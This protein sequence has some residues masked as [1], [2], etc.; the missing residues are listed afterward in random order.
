MINLEEKQE[1]VL[2]VGVETFENSEN[3][4][5]SM[6]ELAEL[7][8]TAGGIVIDAFTQKRD[9]YDTK[10]L[11]GTGKLEQMRWA[12]E[13]G[14]IDTVIFNDRLTPR[15]N[16]NLEEALG[17]KVIDRMQLILD[18]FALRARSH[19][20]MLQVEQAQLSYLLPRLVGQGIMLSRQG[21]GI[22]SK[23][24]GESKLE[25]D[26]RYIRT[27]I[28]NIDKQLQ[29][30]E[31][32]RETIRKKRKESSIF[33]IGLIGYTN[34]GKSSIMNALTEKTQYEKDEL[35]ATLDATTKLVKIK[36]DFTVSLTDTVGF[37]QDLPTELIKAFKSTLEESTHV[38]LLIHVIDASNPHHEVHEKTVQ[39]L[40]EEMD[41]Q[42]IPVL[43][44]YNKMDI[45]KDFVPTLTPAVQLSIKSDE[46]VQWLRTAILE[47]LHE[48]F[49][50][51]EL[52]LPY[53]M[54][55][56]LPELK[57]IAMVNEVV[58]GETAY[59]VKGIIAPSMTWKLDNY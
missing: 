55:Y 58:E 6:L 31:K 48:L 38:D 37:I 3:F 22:G 19:E 35:F 26:R 17:I 16:I 4:E 20:G 42:G 53:A 46:G 12:I 59:K 44:V 56:K 21:G 49:V 9:K 24:P 43:N 1:R 57:K 13:V 40:M 45:A 27:R 54:A 14:E 51:F 41:I 18:I 39:K 32:T 25:T 7:T 50:A 36:E 11:I 10:F 15:Q 2:L 34:A 23:G 47:K 28:E 33:K 29:K 30:V 8:K 5:S 52:D